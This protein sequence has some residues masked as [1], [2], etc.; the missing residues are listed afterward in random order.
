MIINAD[1]FKYPSKK[2]RIEAQINLPKFDV[3][4]FNYID[5]LVSIFKEKKTLHEA[6]RS[7]N[8]Y[9]WDNC[10][11]NRFGKL[12]E[13]FIYTIT[14]YNRGFSDDIS[15]CPENKIVNRISF[16]YYAEIFYYYFFSSRDIIAQIIRLY[17]SIKIEENK[18]HFDN[19]LILKINDLT[20]KD[21]VIFFYKATKDASDYRN[22]FAHRFPLNLPDYRS[23]ITI[24]EGHKSLS[25]GGGGF[26]SSENIV[27][28]II[29]SLNSLSILMKELK[30][31]M[32][33]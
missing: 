19:A 4:G 6:S 17:Y 21:A 2:E 8:L 9:W 18:L 27:E 33:E 24:D 10:L 5:E 11:Q 23:I 25:K 16:D 3:F 1:D 20:V 22:G 30:K 13:T 26:I 29:L 12:R 14:N 31:N 28:N 32:N 7:G 15:L